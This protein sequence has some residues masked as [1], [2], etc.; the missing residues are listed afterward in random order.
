MKTKKIISTILIFAFVF[1][2]FSMIKSTV[3]STD[4]ISPYFYTIGAG[5]NNS[6]AIKK[7]GSLWGWGVSITD[8]IKLFPIKIM[9][10]V[11]QVSTGSVHTMAIKSN[12]SLWAWGY[13]KDGQ[14]GDGTIITRYSPVK[15]MDDVIQVSVGTVHTMAIKKDGSLWAW[16]SKIGQL[17]DNIKENKTNPVK[18][19]NDIIQVSAGYLHTMTVKKDGSLWTWGDNQYGQIGD[20]TKTPYADFIATE[21]N[22]NKTS[23]VKIMEGIKMPFP[24]VGDLLGDILYSDIVSYINGNAIP[25]SVINGKTLV[26]VEDLA[27]YGF[28][29]VWNNGDRTLKVELNKNKKISPL[30]VV[31]DT[32]HKSGTFKCKYVYTDIKTY[33]SGEVV[34]SFAINGVTLINFELLVKYGKL[35]WDGKA[36]E[37]R[38]VIDK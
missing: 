1:T 3:S 19:M 25:T 12:G 33:L 10:D 36:R 15:I 16:G 21:N 14:L 7:D 24:K 18:I 9:D 4:I 11:I 23:P 28:D 29:V 35:T 2:Y 5:S 34:E 17:G 6:I 26:T 37:I 30:P 27:R 8:Q 22:N 13:N 31:K 20:G 38:L 32:T